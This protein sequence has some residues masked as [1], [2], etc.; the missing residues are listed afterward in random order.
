MHDSTAAGRLRKLEKEV[1]ERKGGRRV[2]RGRES[3]MEGGDWRRE[4]RV[5]WKEESGEGK[6]E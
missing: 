1:E 6:G 5:G 3:R 2:E 4:G